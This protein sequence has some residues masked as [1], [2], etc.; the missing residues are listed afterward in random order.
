M[1]TYIGTNAM[2]ISNYKGMFGDSNNGAGTTKFRTTECFPIPPNGITPASTFGSITLVSSTLSVSITPTSAE[3]LDVGQTVTFNALASAG[4]PPY[5][6]YNFIL[7]N[8]ITNKKIANSLVT[9]NGFVYT[10]PA[11]ESGNTLV[12]NVFVTDSHPT[13]VN[14]ILSGVITIKPAL[15]VAIAPSSAETLDV[16]Q[17]ITFAALA[18]GGTGSFTYDFLFT[19]ASPAHS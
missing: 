6:T 15:S 2:A 18:I 8:S 5:T 17:A 1:N 3:T 12:A 10:I 11:G 9:Y 4:T 14:S 7:Y 13:T 16:G 19:T